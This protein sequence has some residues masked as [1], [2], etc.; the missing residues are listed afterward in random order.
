MLGNRQEAIEH[1]RDMPRLSPNDNQGI[2]Y[3]LANCLLDEGQEKE[4]ENLLEQYGDDIAA[5]WSYTHALLLYRQ[6]GP[7]SRA[8]KALQEAKASN[9]FVPLYLLQKNDYRGIFLITWV[10]GMNLKP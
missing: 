1:Y 2:R 7:S 5:T 9:R 8:K 6:E 3:I 10:S 4:L